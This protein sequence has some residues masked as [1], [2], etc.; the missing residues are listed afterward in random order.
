LRFPRDYGAHTGTQLEWWYVT[1]H[2]APLGQTEPSHGFQLTFFRVATGL[3]PLPKGQAAAATAPG[4]RFAPRHILLG[5]AAL[6]D[7]RAGRHQHEQRLQRWNGLEP[8]PS[9][10]AGRSDTALALAGWTLR[11]D[12]ASGA[13]LARI[14]ALSGGLVLRLAPSQPLLLQGEAGFSRKGPLAEQA[15]HYYSQPQLQVQAWLGEAAARADTTAAPLQGRAWLDHEWSNGLMPP[16]SVGWDWAGLNLQDGAALTLFR[17]RRADGSAVW[18]G[19][20][21]RPAGGALRAFGPQDLRWQAGRRWRSPHTGGDY[22]VEWH[23]DTPLPPPL[24]RLHLAALL[25]AQELDG[26]TGAGTIYWE[27][28]SELRDAQG[29]RLGLGYLEM[30]G[31]ARALRV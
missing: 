25:D 8:T 3:W 22:P 28:L 20:S 16:D 1:G 29:Q 27:G 5:H 6:T 31:Y 18:A 24:H 26:R 4:G 21:F 12:A 17:L 15:S 2:L 11:R 19:G 23:I 9:A 13:Y 7:L 30:T 10:N 14:P